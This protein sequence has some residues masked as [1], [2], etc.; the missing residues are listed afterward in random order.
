MTIAFSGPSTVDKTFGLTRTSPNC[1]PSE[2][3]TVCTESLVLQPCPSSANCYT[4][5]I[6]TYDKVLCTGSTC[7]I[8]PGAQ[9]LSANQNIAFSVLLGQANAIRLTL[10]G[11]PVSA[12]LAPASSST[13]KGSASFTISKCVTAPQSVNVVGIDADGNEIVGSG[14]PASATLASNDTTHLEVVSVSSPSTAFALVPPSTIQ[15]ATIPI[16]GT[17]V[18]LTAV[19]KPLTGSGGSPVTSHIRV[20]FNHDICGLVTEYPIP[21]SSSL[22]YSIAA[23]SDGALWFTEHSGN[24]IGRIT[25]SGTITETTIP[26]SSSAPSDITAGSDG[27]LWFTETSGNKIGRITTGA[28]PTITE[29]PIPGGSAPVGIANGPDT[30]IWFIA[31]GADQVGRYPTGGPWTIPAGPY[32]D[33]N[34]QYI[35]AGPDGALWFTQTGSEAIGRITTAGTITNQYPTPTTGSGPLYI[36]A[37]PDTALWFTEEGVNKIGRVTTD[38]SITETTLP[39]AASKPWGITDGADG[40]LWFAEFGN[41]KIGRITTAKAITETNIPT[42]NSQPWGVTTGP[43][44]NVWFTESGANQ[45][46]RLQ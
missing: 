26:T 36:T 6:E 43:D 14:A 16:G 37:G 33:N 41:N 2:S 40:A 18:T 24:K 38:G 12:T 30:G 25:T 39:T 46:G 44:G 1:S 29:T 8:P 4:G 17:V 19:L 32:V 21:T 5:L 9:A 34:A 22:P 20:T 27:A 13:L 28:T 11:I 42:S 45:I 31:T 10:D 23:G 15:A 35:T 3:G 7:V